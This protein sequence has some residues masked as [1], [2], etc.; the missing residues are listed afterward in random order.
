QAEDGIRDRTV[1]GVQTCAL[2]IYGVDSLLVPAGDPAAL[3][4]ALHTLAIDPGGRERMARAARERAERF[5]WPRVT[6]EVVQTYEQAIERAAATAPRRIH[7][8]ALRAGLRPADG[9]PQNPPRRLPS[10]EPQLPGAT[11]RRAA[12]VARRVGVV[13]AGA[14]GV[15]P[16]ALALD[17]TRVDSIVQALLAATP[18]R[19]LVAFASLAVPM[20]AR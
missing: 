9:L 12:R 10:I 5:A 14:L 11:R 7:R 15:G 1:T 16:A 18:G 13:A 3:G 8:L 2:P 17:R 20:R 4:E 6:G 19:V